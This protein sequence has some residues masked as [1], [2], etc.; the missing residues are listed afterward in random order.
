MDIKTEKIGDVLVCIPQGEITLHNSVELRKVFRHIVKNNEKKVVV[1]CTF[2]TA[3]DESGL[4]TLIEMLHRIQKIDG[5][6]K[7]SNMNAHIKDVFEVTSLNLFFE[8][9]DTREN[10]I[11]DFEHA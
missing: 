11:K 10:A 1:D 7:L 8:V 2:L 3:I 6:F 5:H 4:A 9:C